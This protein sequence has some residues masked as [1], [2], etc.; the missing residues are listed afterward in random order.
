MKFL[1]EADD[2]AITLLVWTDTFER[3]DQLI[4]ILTEIERNAFPRVNSI[5]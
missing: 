3:T 5:H 4:K 1:L 2:T